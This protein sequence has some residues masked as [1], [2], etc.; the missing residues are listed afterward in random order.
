MAAAAC[1]EKKIPSFRYSLSKTVAYIVILAIVLVLVNFLF[2][3]A[4]VDDMPVFLQ[5][6]SGILLAVNPYLQYIQAGLIFVFG[7]LAVNAA[8]GVVYTYFRQATEH[9]TAATLRTITRIAGIAVLLAL[10]TSIFNVDP[11]AALTVGSFGG[12]VVGFATQTIFTHVVAGVFLL[13]SRPFTYGDMITVAGQTGTVKEIKLMHVVLETED[14][15]KDIL[16]PSGSIVTQIIQKRLPKAILKPARTLLILEAPV[17]NAKKGNIVTF[18]GKLFEEG[19][20][21]LSGKTV[22]I[23]DVDIGRDD[24]LV[25]GVTQTDGRFT[26]EWKAKKTDAFDNSAEI[27][28][29]FEGDEDHRRSVSKQYIITIETN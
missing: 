2:G 21:P 8:S 23:Y 19:G 1:E 11:A 5:Q 9:A 14:S 20:K 28:A 12:L 13:I 25:S 18:A 22:G 24:L 3:W 27:H 17:A 16:I 10:M 4:S 15:T 6:Y 26:I 29:K 7:Y